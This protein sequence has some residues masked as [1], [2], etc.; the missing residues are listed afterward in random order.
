LQIGQRE[1][2]NL[3]RLERLVAKEE[4]ALT[5]WAAPPPPPPPRPSRIDEDGFERFKV[6]NRLK[7]HAKI[8]SLI[9]VV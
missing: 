9:L 4:E 6:R 8:I 5:N 3:V 2:L 1:R 7:L